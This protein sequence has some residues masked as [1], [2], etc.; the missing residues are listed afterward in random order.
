MYYPAYRHNQKPK[1]RSPWWWIFFAVMF[2]TALGWVY[3]LDWAGV[4]DLPY[5]DD[6]GSKATDPNN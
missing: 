4:I 2:V 6:N 1:K 5:V 3:M